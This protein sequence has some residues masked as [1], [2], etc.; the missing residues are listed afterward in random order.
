MNFHRARRGALLTVAAGS[1]VA[2]AAT[3]PA[4]AA[5][6]N[7]SSD[8]G[9]ASVSD[10]HGSPHAYA[11]AGDLKVLGD[12]INIGPV[13]ESYLSDGQKNDQHSVADFSK[14]NGLITGKVIDSEVHNSGKTRAKADITDL[15]I[16]P[17][18]TSKLPDLAKSL[19]DATKN[20]PH[21]SKKVNGLVEML[22]TNSIAGQAT[23][24]GKPLIHVGTLNTTCTIVDGK[25]KTDYDLVDLEVLGTKVKVPE[26]GSKTISI[27]DKALLNVSAGERTNPK[28]GEKAVNALHIQGLGALKDLLSVDL[29]A[30]HSHCGPAEQPSPAPK[31]KPKP[32]TPNQ[33]VSNNTGQVTK[34]PTGSVNTGGGATA[35]TNPA[36]PWLAG[37]GGAAV[38]AGAGA[39]ATAYRKRRATTQ[40]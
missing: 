18:P 32:A 38:L 33:P 6:S 4:A 7:S 5:S 14:G 21:V 36:E 37:L 13:S 17:S 39:G 8:N 23:N 3:V 12:D 27:G 16:L 40:N 2:L 35:N 22:K 11:L 1:A 28:D 29:V 20:V 9:A 19:P 24:V 15:D 30:S 31:P 34:T 25:V 26:D 10:S